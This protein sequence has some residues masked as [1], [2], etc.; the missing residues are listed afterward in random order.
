M[1]VKDFVLTIWQTLEVTQKT[2]KNYKGAYERYL[3]PVIGDFKV[4]EVT[5]AQIAE[6]LIPYSK[7]TRYVCLM[8]ARVIFREAV[9]V[10]LIEESPAASIKPPRI[11]VVPG[12][13]LPW[14]ELKR[15]DFGRQTQR[16]RFLALHGLRYGEAVALTP[17]DIHD[18]RVF[19][20]KSK[21]GATK[22]KSGIR[23][24]PLMSEFE[25]FPT[26]QNRIADA[27]RPYGVTVHSLRKT[28]AYTLKCSG[29]HVTTASK[30]M[31]HSNPMITLK[32]YTLVLDEETDKAGDAM[33]RFIKY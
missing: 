29:V 20:N 16:I 24:V 26:Y 2:L 14:E 10:G 23:S 11:T 33:K 32:I 18:G 1:K 9:Q 17:A 6:A 30:L 19:I 12:K 25:E 7:Q 5:R 21:Y 4:S 3:N 22:T 27:L 28:Y 31:G 8:V 13:F 15:I